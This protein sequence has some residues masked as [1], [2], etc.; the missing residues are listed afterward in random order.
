[1][2]RSDHADAS[3]SG[4]QRAAVSALHE[5]LRLHSDTP[6]LGRIAAFFGRSPLRHECR[7]WYLAASGQ[8][9]VSTRL[10]ELGSGWTVLQS[11]PSEAGAADVAHLVV[12]PPGV[13]SLTTVMAEGKRVGVTGRSLSVGSSALGRHRTADI[14]RARADAERAAAS[15]TRIAGAPVEVTPVIV[16]VGAAVIVG[17]NSSVAEEKS[18]ERRSGRA[19]DSARTEVLSVARIVRWLS[20][21]PSILKSAAVTGLSTMAASDGWRIMRALTDDAERRQQRFER[22]QH[23]V[24]TA[25]RRRRVWVFTTAGILIAGVVLGVLLTVGAVVGTVAALALG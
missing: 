23:E 18:G 22:L 3:A 1:M 8:L 9:A 6:P 7:S 15:L 25:R 13:F 2:G 5:C 21:R 17:A 4:A 11:Q 24:Q 10:R 14:E 19:D 12:G 16:V 20:L